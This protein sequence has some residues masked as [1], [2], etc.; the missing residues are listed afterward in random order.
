MKEGI[1]DKAGKPAAD[2][3]ASLNFVGH[4]VLPTPG[5]LIKG[6]LDECDVCEP[7][8]Q[9]HMKLELENI[10]LKNV[11]LQKQIDLLEQSQE[12]RCCPAP[13]PVTT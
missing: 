12:Y 10:K 7:A 5:L 3:V 9:Q 2:L 11:L 6:C 4:T 8:L 1:I 13:E